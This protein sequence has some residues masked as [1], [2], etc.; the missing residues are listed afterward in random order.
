MAVISCNTS[1]PIYLI[2]LYLLNVTKENLRDRLGHE[3]YPGKCYLKGFYFQKSSSK[4]III[5][6]FSILN[7]NVH[8]TPDEIFESFVE[9]SNDL[10]MNRI[11]YLKLL[12]KM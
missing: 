6:K 11:A 8:L 9:R 12:E 7:Y 2:L 10:T 5:K 1:E 4:N 3:I